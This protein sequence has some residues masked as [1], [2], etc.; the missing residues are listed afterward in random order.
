MARQRPE[1][2]NALLQRDGRAVEGA[3]FDT[4]R[5]SVGKGGRGRETDTGDREN[6]QGTHGTPPALAH[7]FTAS[8]AWRC[9]PKEPLAAIA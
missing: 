4:G 2:A 6:A 5:Q 3:G 1:D 8:L 9:G 7:E